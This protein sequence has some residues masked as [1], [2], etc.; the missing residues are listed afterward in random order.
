MSSPGLVEVLKEAARTKPGSN[1]TTESS[2]AGDWLCAWC[3]NKVANQKDLFA[4]AG[5]QEF[6]FSNPQGIHFV[7]L[8]FSRTH[9][10][11]DVGVPTLEH[12]WFPGHA[13]SFCQC[14]GCAQ[15]LGWYYTG[16]S[17]FAGLIKP[18]IVRAL[19]IRN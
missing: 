4:Y 5:Q 8:T 9:G 6:S 3:L 16:K 19:H 7:I 12:T 18:R 11:R 2:D 1:A 15:H 14:T 10:C 13:W 17:Q